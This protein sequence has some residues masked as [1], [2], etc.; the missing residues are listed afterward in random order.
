M[1]QTGDLAKTLLWTFL[2][3]DRRAVGKLTVSKDIVVKD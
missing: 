1:E 3:G 2:L